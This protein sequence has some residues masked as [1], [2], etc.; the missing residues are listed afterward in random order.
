MLKPPFVCLSVMDVTLLIKNDYMR[1]VLP[2]FHAEFFG[3]SW[4]KYVHRATPS[5][6]VWGNASPGNL[7]AL[8][9]LLG[10]QNGWKLATNGLLSTQKNVNFK[11]LEGELMLWGGGGDPS[12]PPLCMTPWLH[13]I[14]VMTSASGLNFK[15]RFKRQL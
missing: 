13:H 15:L 12:A 11:I 9:L 5:R 7:H 3:G 6:G 10:L 8:R 14:M 1:S 2:G 4:K